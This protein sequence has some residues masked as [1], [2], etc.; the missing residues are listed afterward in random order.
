MTT[1][2]TKSLGLKLGL[3]CINECLGNK[4]T[5]IDILNGLL[6]N[7]SFGQGNP[8]SVDPHLG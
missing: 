8:Q 3:G 2:V 7:S 5:M 4:V 6:A 1:P